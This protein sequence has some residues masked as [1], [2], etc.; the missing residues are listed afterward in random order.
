[1]ALFTNGAC[2]GVVYGLLYRWCFPIKGEKGTIGGSAPFNMS[3]LSCSISAAYQLTIF[4]GPD[5]FMKKV[6]F[7]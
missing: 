4:Y 2:K 1:M 7:L 3:N 5:R 6:I